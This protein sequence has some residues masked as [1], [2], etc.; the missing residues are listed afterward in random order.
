MNTELI[1][2]NVPV[3]RDSDGY[4]F[5]PAIPDFDEDAKAYKDWLDAQGIETTYKDLEWE[6]DSH[7][8][9]QRY[10][11]EGEADISDWTPEPPKGEGWHTLSIHMH[12]DGVCWVWARR[13]WAS[14]K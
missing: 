12:D 13:V 7:P 1:E 10:F 6:D 5:N 2:L 9:Y 11:E 8:A 14:R 3:E 4:W